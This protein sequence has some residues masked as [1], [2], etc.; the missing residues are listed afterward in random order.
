MNDIVP[1]GNGGNELT[2]LLMRAATDPNFSP[3]N[4]EVA[5]KFIADREDKIAHRAFNRAM[6]LTQAELESVERTGKN[7]HLRARYA[8]LDGML[9]EILPKASQHGLSIR[10]GSQPPV[11]P[12]M[13]CVTC[14]VAHDD[15]HHETTALEGPVVT[16]GSQGGRMQMTA[17]Q[18]VGSTVTYLKRYLLGMVFSLV[19]SDEQ[20]DD[21]SGG[22]GSGGT[23][24]QQGTSPPS[25]PP[26]QAGDARGSRSDAGQGQTQG[27]PTNGAS[28]GAP[29][30][31]DDAAWLKR[32]G[33]RLDRLT[34]V[35]DINALMKIPEI[36][37][38]RAAASEAVRADIDALVE[39]RVRNL[40][41]DATLSE[42]ARALIANIREAADLTALDLLATLP[43]FRHSLL[44][45][46][47][48]E[49]DV[50]DAAFKARAAELGG[51]V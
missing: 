11:E 45:L 9:S 12:G 25:R 51:A 22:A 41:P 43:E 35:D 19:L 33:E 49:Q 39:A 24:R 14:T 44:A 20:D 48:A 26:Y 42:G 23:T 6:A 5:M 16:T 47:F 2:A 13:K 30:P 3:Q 38:W 46:D 31:R 7:D 27:A 34:T 18:A 50:V 17:I 8:T 29:K 10:F 28:N 37:G 4:F 1:A 32:L 40:T 36:A 15:G 21:G